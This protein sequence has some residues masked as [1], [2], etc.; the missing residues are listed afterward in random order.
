MYLY[1]HNG[2]CGSQSGV[3]EVLGYDAEATGKT[4]LTFRRAFYSIF[5]IWTV[6]EEWLL[7]PCEGM[8]HGAPKLLYLPIDT[9]SY[10]NI[11]KRLQL[12][13]LVLSCDVIQFLLYLSWVKQQEQEINKSNTT[14]IFYLIIV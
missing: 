5:R 11:L 9:V 3:D 12:F 1:M 8:Q 10:S 7:R 6:Q 13:A 4:L 2:I 14:R